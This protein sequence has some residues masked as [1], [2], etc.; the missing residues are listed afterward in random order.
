M[1]CHSTTT[2]F[3]KRFP[4]RQG[5]NFFG[6]MSPSDTVREGVGTCVAERLLSWSEFLVCCIRMSTS[7]LPFDKL[8]DHQSNIRTPRSGSTGTRK[9]GA[10]NKSFTRQHAS[11]N[12][13][14]ETFHPSVSR[15][16][17]TNNIPKRLLT[18]NKSKQRSILRERLL[19]LRLSPRQRHGQE[20]HD[21]QLARTVKFLSPPGSF[22]MTRV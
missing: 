2:H 21:I 18:R 9:A 6:R 20:A 10:A 5:N 11:P 22:A 19:S 12:T 17:F 15:D 4:I 14:I 13:P 1:A 8:N 16:G 3:G 7:V